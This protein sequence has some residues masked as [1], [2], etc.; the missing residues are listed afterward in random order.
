MGIARLWE[1]RLE[2]AVTVASSD[3]TALDYTCTKALPP[4]PV[5]STQCVAHR[6]RL[7]DELLGRH[8]ADAYARLKAFEHRYEEDGAIA[9]LV[10]HPRR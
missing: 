8:A 10:T 6:E 2:S 4:E 1:R 7:K 3:A 9:D 5:P